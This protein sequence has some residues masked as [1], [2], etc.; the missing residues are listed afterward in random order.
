MQT[1]EF[2][3]T[4]D[5]DDASTAAEGIERAAGCAVTESTDDF[6]KVHDGLHAA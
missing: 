3:A 4:R 1:A 2:G 5:D 6:D